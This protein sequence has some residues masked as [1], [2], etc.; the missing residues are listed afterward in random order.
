MNSLVERVRAGEILLS[1]GGL[2]ALLL[3]QHPE[4]ADRLCLLCLEHPETVSDLSRAFAAAGADIIQ[5]NTFGASPARLRPLG[6]HARLDQINRAA[7]GI[8]RSAAGKSRFVAA[9]IGPSGCFT[10]AGQDR[11]TLTEA[12]D[13]YAEQ[14]SVLVSEGVDL[15]L[16]ET[17]TSVNDAR[18]ALAAAVNTAPGVLLALSFHF[19]MSHGRLQT[20]AGETVPDLAA[21]LVTH[22]FAFIGVNCAEGIDST[23]RAAI[24][25]RSHFS[26]PLICRP[27]A[28][29]P[30][31]LEE[32]P[33]WPATTHQL[34]RRIPEL[35]EA[36]ASVVGGCCGTTPGHIAAMRDVVDT[37]LTCRRSSS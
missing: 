6:L 19:V 15:L 8:A 11:T 26:M 31:Y 24:E 25:L 37:W 5:S 28:G 32:G 34:A 27:N 16:V 13:S 35:L 7:V 22:D 23:V 3:R 20:L 21:K 12:Q 4:T 9:S 30:R 17:L 10:G 29:Q 2:G 33:V 14:M 36:G 1:D 18:A